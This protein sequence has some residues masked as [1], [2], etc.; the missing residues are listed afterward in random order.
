MRGATSFLGELQSQYP[1]HRTLEGYREPERGMLE[2]GKKTPRGFEVG[3]EETEPLYATSVRRK[4]SFA[5]KESG[6]IMY[7]VTRGFEAGEKETEFSYASSFGEK[8]LEMSKKRVKVGERMHRWVGMQVGTAMID[9]CE[10]YAGESTTED[11]PFL[12][13]AAGRTL[14]SEVM[15]GGDTGL[16]QEYKEKEDRNIRLF[17]D[18]RN[19]ILA[20]RNTTLLHDILNEMLRE[21]FGEVV[22]IARGEYVIA[23]TFDDAIKAARE[24]F[25]DE[26]PKIIWRIGEEEEVPRVPRVGGIR[27]RHRK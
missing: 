20:E 24:K 23:E 10:M 1:F 17:H 21:H 18:I 6:F 2:E 22:V 12:K 27:V 5:R 8:H 16:L 19:K 13:L 14:A 11:F 9:A 25:P 7:G 3:E 4:G 26:E 15:R